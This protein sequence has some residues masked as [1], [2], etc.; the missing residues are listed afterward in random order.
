MY[1]GCIQTIVQRLF[2]ICV[3]LHT[4]FPP[5]IH[6]VDT[7]HMPIPCLISCNR[8]WTV[9]WWGKPLHSFHVDRTKIVPLPQVLLPQSKTTGYVS[10]N[11]F[12]DF[13]YNLLHISEAVSFLQMT[14]EIPAWLLYIVLCM[15]KHLHA[16][17]H[18]TGFVSDNNFAESRNILSST[19]MRNHPS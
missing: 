16:S 4:K 8:A 2:V 5:A 19:S 6:R 14:L 18:H 10:S 13:S 15:Y 12:A 1:F 11:I 17:Y 9:F 3:W 7:F